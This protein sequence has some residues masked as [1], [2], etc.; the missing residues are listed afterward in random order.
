MA[1]LGTKGGCTVNLN[2]MKTTILAEMYEPKKQTNKQKRRRKKNK[3]KRKKRK[4]KGLYFQQQG[5]EV[6]SWLH[7]FANSTTGCSLPEFVQFYDNDS[8]KLLGVSAACF[9]YKNILDADPKACP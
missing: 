3:K 2:N 8:D 4:K 7:L 6:N 1:G 9:E 5:L